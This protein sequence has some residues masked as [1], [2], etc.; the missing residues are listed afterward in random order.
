MNNRQTNLLGNREGFREGSYSPP[1]LLVGHVGNICKK[2]IAE[3]V[4]CISYVYRQPQLTACMLGL[5]DL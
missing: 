3:N 4:L 2:N 5:R 1:S